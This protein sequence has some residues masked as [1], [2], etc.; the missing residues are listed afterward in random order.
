MDEFGTYRERLERRY[1]DRR[2]DVRR[3]QRSRSKVNYKPPS[4]WTL[5]I[6]WQFVIMVLLGLWMALFND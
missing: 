2:K 6:I 3:G 4:F 1:K 5:T